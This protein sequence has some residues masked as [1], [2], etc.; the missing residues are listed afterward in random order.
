[1]DT[2]VIVRGEVQVRR[3][4]PGI[5]CNSVSPVKAVEEEMNRKEHLVWL[6]VHL[7]GNDEISVSND[8]MKVQNIHRFIQERPGRDHYEI[9]VANGEWQARLTP[10]DNTMLYDQALHERLENE[11]GKGAVEVQVIER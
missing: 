2:V 3:D 1:E 9:F 4:E 8:I 7:S 6:T 11:L 10:G 5:L